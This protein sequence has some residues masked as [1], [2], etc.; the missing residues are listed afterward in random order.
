MD[1]ALVKSQAREVIRR[2]KKPILLSAFL[3]LLLVVLFSYLSFRLLTPGREQMAM[4]GEK[5][6]EI[7]RAHV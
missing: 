4:L 3:Y 1:R 5:A 7:G 2:A 6:L